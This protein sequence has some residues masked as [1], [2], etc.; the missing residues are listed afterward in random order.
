MRDAARELA[1]NLSGAGS[2]IDERSNTSIQQPRNIST[3]ERLNLQ[4]KNIISPLMMMMQRDSLD[5]E[6]LAA[7]S[8]ENSNTGM[9]DQMRLA[10]P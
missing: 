5:M 7:S 1:D 4:E 9:S 2:S 10:D 3:E 6:R 8:D